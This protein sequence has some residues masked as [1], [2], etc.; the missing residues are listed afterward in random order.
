M[1]IQIFYMVLY[2]VLNMIIDIIIFEYV[3]WLGTVVFETLLF[4]NVHHRDRDGRP[5]PTISEPRDAHG[6]SVRCLRCLAFARFGVCS[7]L[8]TPEY[9][10]Q[11]ERRLR[12]SCATPQRSLGTENR[13]A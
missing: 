5:R 12:R 7:V 13:S 8:S 1:M 6:A 11:R 10:T 9:A 4:T 2:P 3:V